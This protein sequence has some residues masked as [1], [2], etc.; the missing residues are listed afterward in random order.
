MDYHLEKL[1]KIGIPARS[2][3][4]EDLILLDKCTRFLY[5]DAS[6]LRE[7][8]FQVNCPDILKLTMLAYKNLQ[9]HRKYPIN[10]Q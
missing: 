2:M 5:E 9:L 7:H 8:G 3:E 6:F 1:I 10:L 4:E